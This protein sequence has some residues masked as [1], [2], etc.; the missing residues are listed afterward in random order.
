MLRIYLFLV[1]NLG[2]FNLG[3][4]SLAEA[5]GEGRQDGWGQAATFCI[6]SNA[7]TDDILHC[8]PLVGE[9]IVSSK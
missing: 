7:S 1:G 9:L 5:G 3:L 4:V 6:L 8:C 2:M